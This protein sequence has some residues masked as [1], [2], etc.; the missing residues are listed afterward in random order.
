MGMSFNIADTSLKDEYAIHEGFADMIAFLQHFWPSQVLREQI[1]QV[2]G[3]LTQKSL[4]GPIASQFA[5]AYNMPDGLR[6]P[7]GRTDEDGNWIPH[8]PDPKL[9]EKERVPTTRA[10]SSR[11]P[12]SR[13]SARF[14]NRASRTCVV[15]PAAAPASWAKATCIPTWS[16]ASPARRRR[17]RAI[18]STCAFAR[19]TTCRRANINVGDFLRA[20]LTADFDLEPRD[21]HNYRAAFVDAFSRTALPQGCRDVLRRYAALARASP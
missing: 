18:C 17:R 3:D 21:E 9:F 16:T 15:L 20:L 12:Y 7:I 13:P 6:N 19:W 14:T 11:A 2:R 1:R 4:L 8:R 10:P 5:L